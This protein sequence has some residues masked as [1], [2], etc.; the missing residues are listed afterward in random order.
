M[1]WREVHASAKRRMGGTVDR[2]EAIK[3]IRKDNQR[4]REEGEE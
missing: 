2:R 3:A 4:N 1:L